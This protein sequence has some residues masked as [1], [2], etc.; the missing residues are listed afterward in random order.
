MPWTPLY[1]TILKTECVGNSLSTINSNFEALDTYLS[2]LTADIDAFKALVAATY[3]KPVQ[4]ATYYET[5]TKTIPVNTTTNVISSTWSPA[6]DA[7]DLFDLYDSNKSLICKKAGKYRIDFNMGVYSA[8]SDAGPSQFKGFLY[9]GPS[10][11]IQNGTEFTNYSSIRPSLI[12][13][14]AYH[15]GFK[16]TMDL[17]VN[18]IVKIQGLAVAGGQACIVYQKFLTL[19]RFQYT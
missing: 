14:D 3:A 18:D 8:D 1:D 7:D 15:I 19:E 13:G 9:A 6:D 16:W 10:S 17:N 5:A 4:V 12:P 2:S 11:D